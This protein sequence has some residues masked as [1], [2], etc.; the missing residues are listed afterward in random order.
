MKPVS[1]LR[2]FLNKA[3]F[4]SFVF[5][6]CFAPISSARPANKEEI[7]KKYEKAVYLTEEL[8]VYH[9]DIREIMPKIQL[10]LKAL[11][12]NDLEQS[13]RVLTETLRDLTWIQSQRPSRSQKIFQFKWLEIY[14][15]VVQKMAVLALLAFFWV[16]LPYFKRQL[17]ANRLTPIARI[18]WVILAGFLSVFFSFFDLSRYGESAWAFMD[19]QVILV[20][21]GGVIGGFVP[22]LCLGLL[23]GAF[24][25]I[26]SPHFVNYSGIVLAGG[27]LGGLASYFVRDYKELKKFSLAAGV[28][29]GLF[30]GVVVYAPLLHLIGWENLFFSVTFVALLDGLAVFICGAVV[31]GQLRE[32]NRRDMQ[33]PSRGF[34][35]G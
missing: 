6:F 17:L 18:Y 14:Q 2:H 19:I 16:R 11:L 22:G 25:L 32:E 7:L 31:S 21:F 26:L 4:L 8:N 1:R 20:A 10:A 24:R 23:G 27:V 15:D 12:R 33:F 35:R 9:E 29:A 30:H 5:F 28:A 34:S 13:D 3:V